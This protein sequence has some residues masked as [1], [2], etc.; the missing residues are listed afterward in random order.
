MQLM[1]D[2]VQ[3]M[4]D[5]YAERGGTFYYADDVDDLYERTYNWGL[6]YAMGADRRVLDLGLQQW[7]ATT[8]FF[9]DDIVSRV[10]PRFKPQIHNEYFNLA[11]PGASEWYHKG[12]ANMAFYH[13]GLADPTISE[14]V[15]R[16]RR[17][18]AM[19]MDE[20]PD[21]P[22]Y[23][24]QHRIFRS[25]I[26]SSV[27]PLHHAHLEN[28]IGW[29]QGGKTGAGYQYYGVR[30]SLRPIVEDLEPDWFE[31]SAR[32][33]EILK[34]F[35]EIVLQGDVPHSLGSTA[36]MTNAYLYTHQLGVPGTAVHHVVLLPLGHQVR[37]A[38]LRQR[39]AFCVTQ[40]PAHE[41]GVH[42]IAPLGEIVGHRRP[43]HRR[44]CELAHVVVALLV[45]VVRH[46]DR[47]D[48][49]TGGMGSLHQPFDGH[50]GV[51]Q[52]VGIDQR[53]HVVYQAVA[54]P[55]PHVVASRPI[56]LLG[57]IDPRANHARCTRTLSD[58]VGGL[59]Q[60]FQDQVAMLGQIF[61]PQTVR[62]TTRRCRE[63]ELH[64]VGGIVVMVLAFVP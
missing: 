12:E 62:R 21:A 15:R 45:V 22:N 27:G 36:L 14:N 1:E 54:Q 2:A 38:N 58:R 56:D 52:V 13:F 30:A 26:Q 40:G 18:A 5:K 29:L 7:H 55:D 33:D 24:P 34:L 6:F 59:P 32:R 4:V 43:R 61:G 37:V 63:V 51:E 44:R 57:G 28:A 39:A 8:R 9:A 16:A 47:I 41:P 64:A 25:P 19:Y 48:R 17:F 42:A 3:P 50:V 53:R 49:G 11:T 60:P 31:N 46:Q 35:D 20:D 23:D 10:H